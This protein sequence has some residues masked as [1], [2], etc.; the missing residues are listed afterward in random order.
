LDIVVSTTGKTSRE[1]YEYREQQGHGHDKDFLTVGSMGHCSHIALGVA[2]SAPSR[3]VFCLDGDGAVLMH[4]GSLA[5]IGARKVR[6]FKHIILNNGSHDS[7]GGQPTVGFSV[8]FTDIARACGYTTCLRVD[9]AGEISSKIKLLRSIQGPALLEIRIRR[10][11]RSDLGRPRISPVENKVGFME[12][13]SERNKK[14]ILVLA[15][16]TFAARY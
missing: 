15:N 14:N 6:N 4:M 10:G 16:S 9:N 8:S 3:Q 5:T 1:L 13:L 2:L 11:A 7:V 12:F